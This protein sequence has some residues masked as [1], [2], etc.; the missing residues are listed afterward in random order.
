M[1]RSDRL[2]TGTMISPAY[3]AFLILVFAMT[4]GGRAKCSVFPAESRSSNEA[5]SH[6]DQ[7][8]IHL[9]PLDEAMRIIRRYSDRDLSNVRKPIKSQLQSAF[10][11]I[12]GP[13]DEPVPECYETEE[14]QPADSDGQT[15]EP[16][17]V[18]II[19][20]PPLH[21][22]SPFWIL[23]WREKEKSTARYILF[24]AYW[25]HTI[26]GPNLV[27]VSVVEETGR[28]IRS[29]VMDVGWRT[30]LKKITTSRRTIPRRC[31]VV[32]HIIP[33]S[34][35]DICWEY[36]VLDKDRLILLRLENSH[37]QP[38][39]NEYNLSGWTRGPLPDRRPCAD[40]EKFLDSGN[41]IDQLQALLWFAGCQWTTVPEDAVRE[42]P[43]DYEE[44]GFEIY[45]LDLPERIKARLQQ[46]TRSSNLWVRQAALL[47]LRN[48]P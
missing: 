32:I 33:G 4:T 6:V 24:E 16:K 5:V 10:D 35:A 31:T 41:M 15:K 2:I 30:Y 42:A 14:L 13:P 11:T 27:R 12:L 43:A 46:L 38:V 29:E 22:W 34:A 25:C 23:K 9:V 17:I 26:P 20:T 28:L 45:L 36:L 47:A 37:R 19:S 1:H 3:P 18:Q 39:R 48:G 7:D 8:W 40:W 44:H 21:Q